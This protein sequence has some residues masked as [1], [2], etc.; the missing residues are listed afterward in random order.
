L[1]GTAPPCALVSHGVIQARASAWRVAMSASLLREWR[2]GGEKRVGVG[3]RAP[4]PAPPFEPRA[5]RHRPRSDAHPSPP[6]LLHARGA[7]DDGRARGPRGARHRDALA[8]GDRGAGREGGHRGRRGRAGLVGGRPGVGWQRRSPGRPRG[9]R[10]P[11]HARVKG[12]RGANARAR[13]HRSTLE[14]AGV[15]VPRLAGGAHTLCGAFGPQWRP[16]A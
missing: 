12:A 5:A 2:V 16:A 15:C 14:G 7:D 11:L 13:A 9:G 6:R 3:R 10:T 8:A 4:P 1:G